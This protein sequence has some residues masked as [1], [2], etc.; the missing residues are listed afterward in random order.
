M[1]LTANQALTR[2]DAFIKLPLGAR[3][4]PLQSPGDSRASRIWPR[5]CWGCERREKE[6]QLQA[7]RVDSRFKPQGN[8]SGRSNKRP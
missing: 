4:F 6:E 1:R 7:F 2:I 5:K 3:C 8:L